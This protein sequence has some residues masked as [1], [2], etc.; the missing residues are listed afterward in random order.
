MPRGIPWLLSCPCAK[1]GSGIQRDRRLVPVEITAVFPN[2]FHSL[3]FIAQWSE[4]QLPGD[5]R[6]AAHV[7]TGVNS[8]TDLSFRLTR[9]QQ[10]DQREE[11]QELSHYSISGM[12]YV[13]LLATC[14]SSSDSSGSTIAVSPFGTK[15]GCKLDIRRRS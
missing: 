9:S 12:T 13:P 4:T 5:R 14:L 10:G 7:F 15:R 2:L 1:D 8:S 6:P 3:P 11:E